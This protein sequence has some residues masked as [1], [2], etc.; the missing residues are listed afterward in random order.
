MIYNVDC[1]DFMQESTELFDMIF[2]DPPYGL[3]SGGTTCQNGERV[4]VDKGE[5]DKATIDWLAAARD[6]LTFDGTIWVSG[7][8]HSVFAHGHAM[9]RLGFKILNMI[10]WEKPNP[11][12]NLSCR[13]FTHSTETLIWAARSAASIHRFNYELMRKENGDKQMKSVWQFTAPGA[14]EKTYGKHPTQKPLLLLRRIVRASTVPGDHIFDPFMGSGTT[15]VACAKL[16]RQFTGCELDP[17]Y[18]AL[19]ERRLKNEKSP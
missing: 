9:Q 15:G 10:T 5:W 11:P 19:A 13:F 7:T 2:A 18:Y 14:S 16:D 1:M 12:P 3:S 8:H 4:P 6:H 17:E